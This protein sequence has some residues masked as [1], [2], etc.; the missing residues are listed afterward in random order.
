M[1]AA[2]RITD[3][4][5]C[6]KVEPGPVP[7]VGGPVT[8]GCSTVIIG[9]QPAARVGDAL[10][11]VPATDTIAR[12]EASVIIGNKAAARV[13]DPTSHGGVLAAGCPTVIIGAPDA[14]LRTD[15]PF[16]EDC[17]KKRQKQESK[18]ERNRAKGK[19]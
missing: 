18:A 1:P 11:C 7:H 16:C 13:G 12:G 15:K 8:A 10:T 3:M 19:K 2:A 14:V 6:P 9:N 5:T 4:H 17:T